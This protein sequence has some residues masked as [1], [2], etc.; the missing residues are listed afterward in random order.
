MGS[1]RDYLHFEF[2]E[3]CLSLPPLYLNPNFSVF[4]TFAEFPAERLNSFPKDVLEV[5]LKSEVSVYTRDDRAEL[6]AFFC[7]DPS[8]NE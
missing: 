6:S 5:S 2:S 4:V 3:K 8:A 1:A 7:F